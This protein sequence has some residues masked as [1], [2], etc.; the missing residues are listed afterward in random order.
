MQFR[1]LAEVIF[2][3]SNIATSHGNNVQKLNIFAT[4]SRRSSFWNFKNSISQKFLNGHKNKLY[5]KK[6]N[7]KQ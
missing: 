1:N 6:V 2:E 3:F 5:H 4:R 7:K